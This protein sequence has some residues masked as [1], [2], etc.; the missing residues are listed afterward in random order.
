MYLQLHHLRG[1]REREKRVI[2][3]KRIFMNTS[4]NLDRLNEQ[5]LMHMTHNF[6]IF[7][8]ISCWNEAHSILIFLYMSLHR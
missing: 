7:A 8:M 6:I 2:E 4:L 1:E 5:F 3:M